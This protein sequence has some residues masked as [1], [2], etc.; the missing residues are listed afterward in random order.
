MSVQDMY[1]SSIKSI[2][3]R[4][5]TTS[6]KAIFSPKQLHLFHLKHISVQRIYITSTY[7]IIQSYTFIPLLLKA[8]VHQKQLYTSTKDISKFNTYISLSQK[9]YVSSTHLYYFYQ[10]L[11][12]VQRIYTRQTTLNL[13][14]LQKYLK[15]QIQKTR[16]RF[17]QSTTKK[18]EPLQKYLLK[19]NK[20]D[21]I[22]ILVKLI[23][24]STSR[25]FCKLG[26]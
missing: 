1:T 13:Q 16:E 4:I 26:A 24:T 11:I 9:V 19:S 20:N 5:Y 2:F 10:K 18:I 7:D 17:K 14:I 21:R 12:S 8:Y 6:T 25:L 22:M 15:I 3:Q 23:D